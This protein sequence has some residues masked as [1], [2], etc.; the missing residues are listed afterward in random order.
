L[1]GKLKTLFVAVV[2][3]TI[4]V[5]GFTGCAPGIPK[6]AFKL[7]ETAL[8]DRQMQ[9]RRY[10][11]SSEASILSASTELLQD[12]GFNI[13]ESE[14]RLGLLVCSKERDATEP[15]EVVAVFAL[16]ILNA[17]A[18]GSSSR[19]AWDNRQQIRASLV[20]RP[21]GDDYPGSFFVRITF[22]RTVW[23]TDNRVTKIEGIRDP[24]IY[25]EFFDKLSKSIFLEANQI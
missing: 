19:V 23:D 3:P 25:Q 2:I 20:V 24:K 13:D 5:S 17:A 6:D 21:G 16:A 15:A 4:L 22:Q 7:S 12:L 11:G 14:T 10:D 1:A 18:G 8:Q 9:T